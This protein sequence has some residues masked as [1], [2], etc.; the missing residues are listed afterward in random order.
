[1]NLNQAGDNNQ[2]DGDRLPW[3]TFS[4]LWVA[5]WF[6]SRADLKYSIDDTRAI[7]GLAGDR[8]NDSAK[9]LA[10][11]VLLCWALF[12]LWRGRR[13]ATNVRPFQACLVTLY[14][15]W[16]AISILWTDDLGLTLNKIGILIV[17]S[18]MASAMAFRFSWREIVV[19]VFLASG[20][21]NAIGLGAEI[22]LGSFH[23]LDGLYRFSGLWHP[24]THGVSLAL[25]VLAGVALYRSETAHRA[26]IAFGTT[27]GFTL[28]LLTRS[29]TAVG[30]ALF[31]ILCTLLLTAKPAK[32]Y[33]FLLGAGAAVCLASFFIMNNVA[34]LP[35]DTL[36]MGRQDADNGSLTNR[37]PLWEDCLPYIAQHQ[38]IGFGYGGFW[39]PARIMTITAPDEVAWNPEPEKYV[40]EG[41]YLPDAHNLYIETALGTGLVGAGLLVA[42]LLFAILYFGVKTS[43]TKSQAYSFAFSVL[44][45]LVFEA[46]LEAVSPQPC[47]PLLIYPIMLAKAA[48]VANEPSP[49][50]LARSAEERPQFTLAPEIQHA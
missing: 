5:F 6:A 21:S 43:R 23:P 42:G 41:S 31:V 11:L 1:M 2:S 27:F 49:M 26:W 32:R 13:F 33:L 44:F 15:I 8:P 16:S 29:R 50:P 12:T 14:T 45:W 10:L 7:T 19:F 28:L 35:I 34:A 9:A 4:F 20:L 30:S 46:A 18:L 37:I 47:L 22:A 3:R 24:N 39:T 17:T 38:W 25:M 36:M 40:A 48:F